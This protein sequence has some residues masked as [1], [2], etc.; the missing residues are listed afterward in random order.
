MK[1]NY[2]LQNL[3]PFFFVGSDPQNP[4]RLFLRPF[5]QYFFG[6][7]E[8]WVSNLNEQFEFSFAV[9]QRVAVGW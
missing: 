8:S 3:P 4:R 1:Q 5:L 6:I 9:A 2:A 7:G